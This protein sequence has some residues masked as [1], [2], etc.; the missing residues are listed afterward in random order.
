M[1]AKRDTFLSFS[2]P[3][4]GEEEVA[5]V[6]DTLRSDWI[7][8]GPKTKQFEREFVQFTGAT[9]A[10]AVS[11]GTDNGSRRG[12]PGSQTGAGRRRT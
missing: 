8:T 5:E 7:T 1:K 3:L 9:A 10:L 11:S 2:P 6:A 4:L 12:A